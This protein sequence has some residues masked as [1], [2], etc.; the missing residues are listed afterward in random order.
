MTLLTSCL[1]LGTG[2]FVILAFVVLCR[3][4]VRR[5]L[6]AQAAELDDLR[7]RVQALR[8]QVTDL[9]V[10]RDLA[11]SDAKLFLRLWEQ[12]HHRD[13]PNHRQ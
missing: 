7:Y 9:T 11:N 3:I 6:R 13:H 4:C 2:G 12:T 8:Q 1:V 10:D 5:A